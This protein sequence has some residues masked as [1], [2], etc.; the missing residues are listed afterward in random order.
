[1]K[2]KGYQAVI[3]FDEEDRLFVGRVIN[4]KDII[5][6]DGLSVAELEQSFH[7]VI[8]EYL[9]DC[10]ELGKEPNKPFS[11]K[12]NLRI[13]PDLHMKAATQAALKGIS[14]NSFVEEAIE[15]VVQ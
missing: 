7:R 6:F 11:G 15:K 3:E 5:V 2:Y 13:S 4:T 10:A 14:L 8:D 12:F 1:M 9:E